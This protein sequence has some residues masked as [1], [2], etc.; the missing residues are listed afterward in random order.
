MRKLY[1]LLAG[2][3]TVL[4]SSQISAQTIIPDVANFTIQVQTGNNVNFTNTSV[5]GNVQGDRKAF[6]FFGDG[7][8]QVTPPL[9]NT[10]HH[11][12]AGGTFNVCL[13]I[14]R[15][16]FNPNNVRDSVLTASVCKTLTLTL[17]ATC[18][19]DFQWMDSIIHGPPVQHKV[20]FSA[21]GT[22]SLNRPITSVCWNFG[23]GS[24]I[25]CIQASSATTPQQLLQTTHIYNGPGPYNACVKIT[26]D[27][28]CI[29]EKCRIIEFP[30]TISDSC[31]AN[32]ERI[33]ISATA[34]PLQAT[35]KAIP[36]HNNNKKPTRICWEFGDG[37]DSCVNYSNTFTGPYLMNHTYQTMGNYQVCVKIR[38]EGGC[39][40]RKCETIPIA[41]PD[42]CTANFTRIPNTTN[43]PLTVNLKALP[44]HNNNKKPARICWEFG[45]GRDT[46]IDYLNLYNGSYNVSHTYNQP[47]RY[48]VCVKIR[49][50]GG[51]EARKCDS[52]RIEQPQ[53]TC[54]VNL[55]EVTQSI[56]SLTRGFL[57]V[58]NSNPYSRP[59]RVCWYFGDGTDSCIIIDPNQPVPNLTMSHTY[60]GPGSYNTCVKI[61]YANGC[62]AHSCKTITI[63]SP[64]SVC[65]GYMRDSLVG[66]RTY[67]FKGFSIHSPGDNVVSWRWT[68]GDGTTALGQNVTHTYSTG[69]QFRVCLTIVTQ[70]GCETKIC[71]TIAVPG[72]N[73]PALVLTPNPV[74]NEL[75]A[76]FHSTLTEPVTIR[77]TNQFGVVVRTYSRN[78]VQGNNNWSFDVTT[79]TP[80]LYTFSV[81]SS[82]QLASAIFIKL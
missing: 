78:A 67:L 79:L 19:A 43:N 1:A 72:S 65:G 22:N 41:R 70:R 66:P 57:A 60:P 10:Q 20:K 44:W 25:Q 77:I 14:Y 17:T 75:H 37:T 59:Q 40:A 61:R 73:L 11:Y 48:L 64:N 50:Y 55:F 16:F 23:D 49:Y 6:W 45:D 3:I 46:C 71:K 56:N 76:L 24:P 35:F 13:K 47:G 38:Y 12:N 69:G 31:R 27:G 62:E 5:I 82:T 15:Y 29:A 7:T 2:L 21:F 80:G 74:H 39:E 33:N 4:A 52:V 51:C 28:G 68:F 58:P 34:N 9:A 32:F 54:S 8:M 63:Q 36:W 18:H 81:Q 42:S 26:Y 30:N 53:P